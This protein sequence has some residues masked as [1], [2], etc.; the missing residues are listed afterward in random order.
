[1]VSFSADASDPDGD[2]LSYS[3]TFGNGERAEG[4]SSQTIV[5]DEPGE[6]ATAE[7]RVPL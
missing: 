5:Y 2:P 4:N 7:A 3:W 6:Y 1:M